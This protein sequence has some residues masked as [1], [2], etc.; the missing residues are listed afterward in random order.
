[1]EVVHMASGPLTR[2]EETGSL[3]RTDWK[4][5]MALTHLTRRSRLL[6][7]AAAVFVPLGGLAVAIGGQITIGT[8]DISLPVSVSVETSC[9]LHVHPTT[10]ATDNAG[11]RALPACATSVT[12]DATLTSH[13]PSMPTAPTAAAVATLDAAHVDGDSPLARAHRDRASRPPDPP[14]L[15]TVVLRI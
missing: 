11:E 8:C 6:A 9:G 3:P 12:I 14:L 7:L 4:I 1:M 2:A 10:D 13:G 15:A 5:D